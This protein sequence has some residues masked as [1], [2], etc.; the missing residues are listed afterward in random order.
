MQLSTVNAS[1]CNSCPYVIDNIYCHIRYLYAPRIAAV[2]RQ[3][4]YT[5]ILFYV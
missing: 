2:P 3:Y 1:R 4:D 5:I